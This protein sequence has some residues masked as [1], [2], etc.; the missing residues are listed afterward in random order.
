[1]FGVFREGDGVFLEDMDEDVV[2]ELFHDNIRVAEGR[3][4]ICWRREVIRQFLD[5][6]DDVAGTGVLRF[7]VLDK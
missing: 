4:S 5:F 7:Q 2:K 3:A 1:M 6:F